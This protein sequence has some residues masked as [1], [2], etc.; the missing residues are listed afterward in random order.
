MPRVRC[1]CGNPLGPPGGGPR[2]PERAG[3][4]RRGGRAA[5]PGE[6]GR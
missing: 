5:P 3:A 4:G 6:Q 2:A 1:A